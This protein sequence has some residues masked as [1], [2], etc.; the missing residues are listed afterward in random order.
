MED[1]CDLSIDEINQ[2]EASLNGGSSSKSSILP[3]AAIPEENIISEPK[4][5]HVLTN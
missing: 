3:E 2:E 5:S 4:N 1:Q